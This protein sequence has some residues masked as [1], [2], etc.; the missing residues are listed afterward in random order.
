M[1][2]VSS[3]PGQRTP[4]LAERAGTVARV[5]S[6]RR[7]ST[8]SAGAISSPWSNEMVSGD[9]KQFSGGIIQMR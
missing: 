7:A 4:M 8:G 2:I 6:A 9:R 3:L 5:G 1:F